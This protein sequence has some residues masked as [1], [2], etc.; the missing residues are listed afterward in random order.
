MADPSSDGTGRGDCRA[1]EINLALGMAHPSSKITIRRGQCPFPPCQNT[2][3]T[4]E[5]W[6]AGGWA[7][8]SIGRKKYF[9]E[10]FLQGLMINFLSGRDHD[11]PYGSGNL[12]SLKNLG[13]HAEVIEMT[14]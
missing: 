13:C 14:I 3:I 4:S 12:S 5:A 8:D 1:R 7:D 10:T 9:E 2:H 6:T 11:Q